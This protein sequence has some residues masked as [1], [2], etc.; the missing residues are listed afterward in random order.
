MTANMRLPLTIHSPEQLILVLFDELLG[1]L[2]MCLIFTSG[3]VKTVVHIVVCG[4]VG[5]TW[6]TLI[7]GN[8]VRR[9]EDVRQR[10]YWSNRVPSQGLRKNSLNIR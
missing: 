2:Q 8:M 10:T 3:Y 7:S 6:C 9:Q 1:L 5:N 4:F